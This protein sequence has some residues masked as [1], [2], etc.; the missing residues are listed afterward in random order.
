[1]CHWVTGAQRSNI[2]WW[3]QLQGSTIKEETTNL[4]LKYYAQVM[5][6]CRTIP[7]KKALL[8]CCKSLKSHKLGNVC[9]AL[10][11]WCTH[12]ISCPRSPA[13]E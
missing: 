13:C 4:S 8:Y 9:I 1:M 2:V 6:L 10:Q 12:S 7:Q 5:Q 3:S 11:F